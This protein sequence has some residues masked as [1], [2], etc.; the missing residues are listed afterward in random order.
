MPHIHKLYD[1]VVTPF[2]IYDGKVLLVDHP[3]Y[4]KW[5]PPGGHI[6]LNENPEEALYREVAEETG[7]EIEL[8]NKKPNLQTDGTTSMPTPDYVDVHYAHPPHRHISLIYFVRA[9]NG[10]FKKSDEHA[11]MRWVGED[12]LD[13][14][15]YNLS[16][17]IKFYAKKAINKAAT[18]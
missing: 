5:I 2:I 18:Y 3:R 16:N 10:D 14:P 1:F 7:L 12:E 17:D 13:K 15:I 6:E 4:G 11:D 8:L 9:L